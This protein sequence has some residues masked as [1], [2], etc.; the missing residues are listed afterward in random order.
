[1]RHVELLQRRHRD[2]PVIGRPQLEQ[3]AHARGVV[4]AAHQHI[5]HH[6]EPT[7]DVELLEHHRA[8][9]APVAQRLPFE[10]GHVAAFPQNLATA[11]V[12]Q[13][14][15]HAQQ[16]GLAGPGAPD[17]ADEAAPFDL[18]RDIVHGALGTKIPTNIDHFQHER[19][20]MEWER[21]YICK[22]IV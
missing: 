20:L 1:M 7:D 12:L 11:H 3:R 15:D 13:A 16:R 14:V 9:R 4:E 10:A 8:R 18:Q 6:V 17:D 22:L 2:G 21:C 5:G 19:L